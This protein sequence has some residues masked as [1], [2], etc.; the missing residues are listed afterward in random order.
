ML[1]FIHDKSLTTILS[2]YADFAGIFSPNRT[3]ELQKYT[4]IN[5]HAINLIES[6]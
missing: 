2:E 4:K 3:T 5:D 6:K 1:M